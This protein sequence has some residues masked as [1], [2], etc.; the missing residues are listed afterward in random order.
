[1]LAFILAATLTGASCA[2][3]SIVTAAVTS[4]TSDGKLNHYTIS[5]TVRNQGTVRQ[6]SNLLQSLDVFQNDQKVGQIG[7]Q[8]LGPNQS[9]K[10]TYSFDRSA[11]AGDGTTKL[12]FTLDLNGSSGNDVDCHQ[13]TES[14][15]IHV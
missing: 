4:V 15:H 8:S 10:V 12:T 13:G 9:Q 5:I 11:D 7:L 1:M 3:P 2:N 6:P 14:L